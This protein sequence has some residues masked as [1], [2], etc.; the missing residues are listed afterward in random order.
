MKLLAGTKK[1]I[2]TNFENAEENHRR[3]NARGIIFKPVFS[4]WVISPNGEKAVQH[5]CFTFKAESI[6]PMT[7]TG[8]FPF[9]WAPTPLKK[10]RVW[11]ETEGELD[12][13]TMQ[14]V[15]ETNE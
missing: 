13:Q 11:L 12:I 6:K 1:I 2:L 14:D 9:A 8:L 7:T 4:V 15:K 10:T 3:A 5:D